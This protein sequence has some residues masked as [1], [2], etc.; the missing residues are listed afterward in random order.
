MSAYYPVFLDLADRPALVVGGGPVAEGKVE[1]L[2]AAGA[3]V[4]VVSPTVTP[5][6]A[7]WVAAG[8]IE[9][10]RAGVPARGPGRAP[11]RARRHRR[12][13]GQRRGGGGGAAARRLGQRRRR[14]RALRLH[15]ARGDPARPARGRG[16]HR[17]G[18]PGGGAGDP[19]RAGGLSHRGPRDP[20]RAGRRRAR[21]PAAAGGAGGPGAL[22]RARWMAACAGSSPTSATARRAPGWRGI[23]SRPDGM[24]GGASTSS[25]RA[26]A[27]PGS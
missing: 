12:S 4:T 6:L 1:G 17:R 24:D 5:R 15:P 10:L 3:H 20:G 23:S 14:A 7:G 13:G 26:R 18:E 16:V 25:G 11:A 21:R 19:G 9:H 2:L 8:R 22:A 27:I